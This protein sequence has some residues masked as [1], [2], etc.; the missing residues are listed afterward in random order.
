MHQSSTAEGGVA[1]V[2]SSDPQDS[3][4]LVVG[5]GLLMVAAHVAFRGWAAYRSYFYAD[6]YTLLAQARDQS[7]DR[8]YLGSTVRRS[9]AS[10]GTAGHVGGR[11]HRDP[12]LGDG[13][14]HHH[15]PRAARLPG[16]ARGCSSPLFGARWGA[17]APLALYLTTAI[18][19]PAFIWWGA[20]IL[21]LGTQLAFFLAV[22]AWVRYLRSRRAPLGAARLRRRRGRCR[23]RHQGPGRAAGSRLPRPGVLRRG[24][25]LAAGPERAAPLLGGGARRPH[26]GRCLRRLLPGHGRLGDQ[27]PDPVRRGAGPLRSPSASP[28]RPRCSAGPGSGRRTT[29]SR[30]RAR[31]RPT[32]WC[33]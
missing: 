15:G 10:R 32:G 1:A 29:C 20:T 17:L 8:G 19:L 11:Q 21:Q 12:Q 16:R 25:S 7:L 27:P 3:R 13:R 2:G 23:L 14:D 33:T 28:S 31:T 30:R 5:A 6:D 9:P 4:R 18:T 24:I 22:G 26:G